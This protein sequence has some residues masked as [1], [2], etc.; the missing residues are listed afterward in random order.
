MLF[1][2]IFSVIFHLDLSTVLEQIPQTGR[3]RSHCCPKGKQA[4]R[5]R[6]VGKKSPYRVDRLA[7]RILLAI[8]IS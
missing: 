7:S 8:A 6:D 3:G 2:G 1:T 5:L 4:H